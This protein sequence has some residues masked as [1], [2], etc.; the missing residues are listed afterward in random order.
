MP[1]R[2]VMQ[3]FLDFREST[4]TRHYQHQLEKTEARLH[5]VEGLLTALANL[6]AIIDILRQ[7]A[8]GTTAKQRFQAQFNLSERQSDAILAMPLRKLTG[9][10]RQGL[11]T[12]FAEL[13]ERRNQ[14]QRLLS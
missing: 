10:E 13:T 11:E 14:L 2:E 5:I 6:D 3:A 7:S 4:L 8:D 12:E 1:L 9:M